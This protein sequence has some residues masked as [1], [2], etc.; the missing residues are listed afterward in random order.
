[1]QRAVVDL[2]EFLDPD[3]LRIPA[4]YRDRLELPTPSATT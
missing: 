4:K 3:R 2:I 1:L